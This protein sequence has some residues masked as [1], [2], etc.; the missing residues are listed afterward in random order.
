[1]S[2]AETIATPQDILRKTIAHLEHVLPGQG[3]IL[4]FVHHNTIHG[5]QHLPFFQALREFEALTGISGFLPES[6]HRDY[7][8]RGRITDADLAAVFA[9]EKDL[10]AETV[11]FSFASRQVKRGELYRWAL[12]HDQPELSAAQV[13]WRLTHADLA[14]EGV[15][16]SAA[17]LQALW[18]ALLS[19]LKVPTAIPHAE[20]YAE[21]TDNGERPNA[22]LT[23]Q[24][25]QRLQEEVAATFNRVGKDWTLRNLLLQLS[26]V[27]L[28]DE[29]RPQLIRFGGSLLDEGLATWHIADAQT[30]GLYQAWR[31]LCAHDPQLMLA[32]LEGG[33]EF[34]RRLPDDSWDA[35]EVLLRSLGIKEQHWNHYLE[36]L[37]LELPGWA[38]LINWRQ[39]H[40]EYR[41]QNP[42]AP[43]LEDFLAVRLC[44]DKL[45]LDKYCR[46][47]WHCAG[48]YAALLSHFHLNP[49]ELYVRTLWQRGVLPEHLARAT[50]VLTIQ[51]TGR[52]PPH[53]AWAK[54]ALD[55]ET[56]KQAAGNVEYTALSMGRLW[57]LFCVCQQL[58]L[59]AADVRTLSATQLHEVL[60]LLDAFTP[61]DR[62]RVWLMAFERHY[63]DE[64]LAALAAN[65]KRGGWLDR[66]WRPDM[67][68]V[69]CMDEREESFRRHLEE[70]NPRIETLGVAGFFGVPMRFQGL[71]AKHSTPLCPVVVTPVHKVVELARKGQEQVLQKHRSGLQRLQ[72]W[73][74]LV[75]Q[76]LRL[77]PLWGWVLSVIGAPFV[78]VMLLLH[79]LVPGVHAKL[80][81]SFKRWLVP[82]VET[83]I[84][85]T[86][87][88]VAEATNV[89]TEGLQ[90]GFTLDEQRGRV[91][92]LLRALG[93]TRNFAPIVGLCGH[94][95]TTQNNP[96]K[97]AYDCGACGGR[98]GGANARAFAAMANNPK[99]RALLAEKDGIHIPDDTWFIGMQHDT[100]SDAITWYDTDLI[101]SSFR[102]QY[103]A[104]RADI[105]RA[106]RSGAH[107]RCRRFFS[108]P[109]TTREAAFRHVTL[110]SQDPSQARPE[111]GHATNAA[112]VIG[113]RHLTQGVFFDRRLFLISYDATQDPTGAIVENILLTAGPVGAGINLEYYFS[114]VDNERFGCGTKIPHNVTGLCAVMEGA[115]SDLRTGLP[116][117]TVEIH[118]AMR[119]QVIVEAKT[120]VLAQIYG[121]QPALQELVGGGW[122]L[123][124]AV[125]PET[126]EISVFDPAR[127]F[128]PWQP[129]AEPLPEREQSLECYKGLRTPV[130]PIL[131]KRPLLPG[132]PS[133]SASSDF[134]ERGVAA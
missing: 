108:A 36:R 82:P 54:L 115:G 95:S 56:W 111:Y 15:N 2:S 40:P 37:A 23:P 96:H 123:L 118:E 101:P 60:H 4:D 104:R 102:A 98:Q 83:D 8:K 64:V 28:L 103:E 116:L 74:Q 18:D 132:A 77:S 14:Q 51:T 53:Q 114:T 48:N 68:L 50:E 131:I 117:Q 110:R 93:L 126:G 129:P 119:L 57:R 91:A 16:L 87:E 63:R 109:Q 58:G 88:E 130:S 133:V 85:L 128:I 52:L 46:E 55:V 81:Q 29:V 78:L 6:M 43:R 1:M 86:H 70:L 61:S 106:Q 67:Q 44:L 24:L 75:H 22:V 5:L 94:G 121:R 97:S 113:R 90:L 13:Q 71:D 41:T 39:H 107:E 31:R 120:E 49:A 26:G 27:D 105:E 7:Y 59:G 47:F 66:G 134:V 33:S 79:S 89:D 100:C 84:T 42:G 112:A 11:L 127:G 45:L 10:Q 34:I 32:E 17:D 73:T 38:G 124:N 72:Q 62:G 20:D 19:V 125:D 12:L 99:V 122:L 76:R 9:A 65:A 92:T 80:T 21:P 35:L 3:P 30:P 25:Q 69:M